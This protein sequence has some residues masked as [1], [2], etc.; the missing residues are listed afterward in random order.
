MIESE[1]LLTAYY[2]LFH[3][4]LSYGVVLWG[5]SSQSIRTFRL[6]KQAIR[7]LVNAGY[8]DHCQQLFIRYKILPVPSIYY[9][10][11]I[12]LD[13]PKN[14]HLY[15]NNSKFHNY[16][17]RYGENLRPHRYRL[18]IS[19]LSEYSSASITALNDIAQVP[20]DPAC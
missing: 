16:P 9:I 1:T 12:L 6:Q 18:E 2:S 17:T 4:Y 13:I 3:S 14:K 20:V 7:L 5:N 8:K 10:F 11:H 19:A 15:S